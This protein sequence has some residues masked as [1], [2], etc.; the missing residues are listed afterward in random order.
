MKTGKKETGTK[1]LSPLSLLLVLSH[2]T[3]K[4]HFCYL[5]K[6]S[7][8]MLLLLGACNSNPSQTQQSQPQQKGFE[9]KFLVGSDLKE[10]CEQAAQKFNKTQAK[11]DDGNPFKLTCEAQGSGDVIN[12]VLSL[13]QQLQ[14]EMI[15]ENDPKFPTLLSVDGE[16]YQSQLIYE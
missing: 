2:C 9:V 5:K 4:Y 3:K 11:T 6:I 16:I 14:A 1:G 10:F 12:T 13:A 15:N 8:G 7:L